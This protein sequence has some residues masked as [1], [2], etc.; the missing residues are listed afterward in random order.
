MAGA[1]ADR[2]V[3]PEVLH[4][5]DAAQDARERPVAAVLDEPV[6]PAHGRGAVAPL[7]REAP[8]AIS[9]E[10][11]HL[12]LPFRVDAHCAQRARPADAELP[13]LEEQRHVR[14]PRM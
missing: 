5:D 2:L 13:A 6:R 9:P 10:P 3:L 8:L 14:V 11:A 12:A 7:R 1:D 4:L